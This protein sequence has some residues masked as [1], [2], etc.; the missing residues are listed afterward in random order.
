MTELSVYLPRE[1]AIT[2]ENAISEAAIPLL[3]A[4]KIATGILHPDR[5]PTLPIS[6]V[7]GLSADSV[8][9]HLNALDPHPQYAKDTDLMALYEQIEAINAI[10]EANNLLP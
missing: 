4:D 3:P 5:I 10:L 8:S 7:A 2:T 9:D 1:I 6:K